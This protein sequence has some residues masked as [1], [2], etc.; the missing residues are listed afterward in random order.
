MS[1]T[2]CQIPVPSYLKKF[3]DHTYGDKFIYSERIL[4]LENNCTTY[5]VGKWQSYQKYKDYIEVEIYN[6]APRYL[7]ALKRALEKQ[8]FDHFYTYVGIH[9]ELNVDISEAVRRFMKKYRLTDD[10]Y[11]YDTFYR[12]YHRFAFHNR[13]NRKK[14]KANKNPKKIRTNKI[15]LAA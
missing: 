10:D 13:L 4:L 14:R 9:R 7:V 5:W 1:K 2:I 15:P 6:P 11:S 12:I 3:V 8:F